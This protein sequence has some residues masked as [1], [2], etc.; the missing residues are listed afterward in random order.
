[1][2]SSVREIADF[3][4]SKGMEL[5]QDD[6]DDVAAMLAALPVPV[7]DEVAPNIWEALAQIINDPIYSGGATLPSDEEP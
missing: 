3:I 5:R 4:A 2:A 1:M 7:H 6:V